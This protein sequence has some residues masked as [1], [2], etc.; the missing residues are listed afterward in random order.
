M[1]YITKSKEPSGR[2]PVYMP[3]F[4]DESSIEPLNKIPQKN[5]G[6]IRG[7]IEGSKNEFSDI[8]GMILLGVVKISE[9]EY[10]RDLVCPLTT[11][12]T[13]VVVELIDKDTLEG[14]NIFVN[15][16][17]GAIKFIKR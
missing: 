12:S 14:T 7:M 5:D 10:L 2:T 15:I 6:S 16:Y 17:K 1:K 8:E 11:N 3:I 4:D 9:N 13:G